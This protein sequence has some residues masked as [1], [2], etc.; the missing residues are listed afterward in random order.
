[1]IIFITIYLG[2]VFFPESDQFYELPRLLNDQRC[3]QWDTCILFCDII[4]QNNSTKLM[5]HGYNSLAFSGEQ[6][7]LLE[8]F[9]TRL[10]DPC[11]IFL[12]HPP[13]W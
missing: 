10:T 8:N 7:C 6:S 2:G 9:I 4:Q 5:K 3:P 13:T 1:L 11:C 12:P